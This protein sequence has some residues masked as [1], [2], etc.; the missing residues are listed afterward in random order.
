M[1]PKFGKV[2]KVLKSVLNMLNFDVMLCYVDVML[3]CYIEHKIRC[4]FKIEESTEEQHHRSSCF[5]SLLLKKE[6][7]IVIGS[8]GRR[9]LPP[10]QMHHSRATEGMSFLTFREVLGSDLN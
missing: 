10:D 3:G 4:L 6:T 2:Q 8:E 1:R 5:H 7:V 9:P